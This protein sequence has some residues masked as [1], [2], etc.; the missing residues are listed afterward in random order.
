M[1]DSQ[2]LVAT[3][4]HVPARLLERRGHLF[5]DG[6]K[7]GVLGLR[8]WDPAGDIAI[9]QLDG[10]PKNLP[11]LGLRKDTERKVGESVIAIGNPYGF[12]FTPSVGIIS[13]VHTTEQLP[14]PFSE[15]IGAPETN[16]W[17]QTSA[18]IAGGSSGGPLLDHQGRVVGIVTWAAGSGQKFGFASDVRTTDRPE[19]RN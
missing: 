10:T 3:C 16:V 11:A 6:K 17:I 5:Q 13:G 18:A 15:W 4:Y 14:A 12:K 1:A 2:G 7:V 19:S 9:V 8:A